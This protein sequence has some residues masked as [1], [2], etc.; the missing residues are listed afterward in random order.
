MLKDRMLEFSDTREKEWNLL[1]SKVGKGLELPLPD[2][3]RWFEASVDGDKIKIEGA[4]L[5]VRPIVLHKPEVVTFKDFVAVSEVYTDMLRG[6]V[7][8]MSGK[9]E[10]QK[11]M[12]NFKYIFMLIYS[13]I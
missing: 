1:L 5:N 10:L 13:L 3:G 11:T 2:S 4:K 6:G 9:L 12:T 7:Q 8:V